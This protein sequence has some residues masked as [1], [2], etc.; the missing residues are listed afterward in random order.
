MRTDGAR[1]WIEPTNTDEIRVLFVVDDVDG[2]VSLRRSGIDVESASSANEALERLST[3]SF[4]CVVSGYEMPNTDGIV[5]LKRV[6]Q[7]SPKLPF[8]LFPSEGSEEI[9]SEA[10]TAGVTDYLPREQG[11][12]QYAVLANRIDSAVGRRRS[13]KA[14]AASRER[15]SLLIDQSTVGVVEWNTELRIVRTNRAAEKILGYEAS[16]LSG[17]SLETI[18]ADAD[19][20]AVVASLERLIEERGGHHGV[21]GNVRKDGERIYCEWH[22]RVIT[23]ERGDVVTIFSQFFDVTDRVERERALTALHDATREMITAASRSEVGDVVLEA[24]TDVLGLEQTAIHFYDAAEDV[25]EPVA[26]NDIAEEAIGELPSLGPGTVAYSVFERLESEL[27]NDLRTADE[28]H[29]PETELRSELL[30]PI[31]DYGIAIVSSFEPGVFDETDRKLL[32][33]IC[34]NAAVTMNRIERERTIRRREHELSRENRRLERFTTIVSHDLRTPLT[35]AAGRVDLAAEQSDS[36]HLQIAADALDRMESLIEEL[37]ALAREGELVDGETPVHLRS[38]VEAC[39]QDIEWPE[40]NLSV[41]TDAVILA[42]EARLRQLLENLLRNAV[43]HG[44]TDVSVTV[45]ATEDG[46]YVADD[47][48]GLPDGDSDRLFE[49]G[50]TT[51]ERGTGFGLSIVG[52]VVE[53]HGWSIDA[54]GSA[55]DGARFDVDGVEFVP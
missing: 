23:D 8:I 44:G 16:E 55:A 2:A 26:W 46:F 3:T 32:E 22:N 28:L 18:V 36:D 27:Y 50:Y 20:E 35:V 24:A 34:T 19:R 12:D 53:A 9:A 31:G 13:E 48:P 21:N 29:N 38:L 40:S 6:R 41:E 14:L 54:G 47:G 49:P 4:D 39:W 1:P 10:I 30:V 45:G 52:E 25:L 7:R 51:S 15:L 42:D 43:E 11:A 5:L 37:L 33:V 17:R